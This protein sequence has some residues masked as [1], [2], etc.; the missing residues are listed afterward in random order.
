MTGDGVHGVDDGETRELIIL[1]FDFCLKPFRKAMLEFS[2][3]VLCVVCSTLDWYMGLSVT[4]GFEL[5][6]RSSVSQVNLVVIF[7]H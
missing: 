2:L 7:L 4:Y 6:C 5:V 1:V 3:L